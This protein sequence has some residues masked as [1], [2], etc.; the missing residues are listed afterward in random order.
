MLTQ[1]ELYQK[2]LAPHRARAQA[3]VARRGIKAHL[4]YL[5]SLKK[6]G[7]GEKVSDLY[8]L[9][10]VLDEL[11]TLSAEGLPLDMGYEQLIEQSTFIEMT[12]E[13]VRGIL[14]PP[15][16]W[17]SQLGILA[18]KWW[19]HRRFEQAQ[20]QT[21]TVSPGLA[22]RMAHTE[23]RGLNT[24]DLVLPFPSIYVE[25]PPAA[26]LR[27]YNDDTG[28]HNVRGFYVCEDQGGEARTPGARIWRLLVW[29]EGKDK[30]D[31]FDDALMYFRIPLLPD[32]PLEDALNDDIHRRNLFSTEAA[33]VAFHDTWRAMFRWVMNIVFYSTWPD[34]VCSTEVGN[35]VARKLKA[36]MDKLP[37]GKKRDRLRTLY[38][39]LDPQIRIVL[40]RGIRKLS[41][42]EGAQVERGKL[43]VRT[44]VAGHWKR[45]PYGPKNSL[46][47]WQQRDPVWR[48]DINAPVAER[49]TRTLVEPE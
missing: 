11:I 22:E 12:N 27:V 38:R 41:E 10:A 21:Y 49:T 14:A 47:K 32:T 1:Y 28:Y 45:Q 43:K 26:G 20:R 18:S 39:L 15:G 6:S 31:P 13:V 4:D 36:R 16:Y 24:D 40:G 23:L 42:E 2:Q 29:G 48:G 8:Y 34:A 46:R 37:K 3:E 25:A 17:V 5:L 19:H 33:R 35:R 44:L 30:S 7:R 9:G